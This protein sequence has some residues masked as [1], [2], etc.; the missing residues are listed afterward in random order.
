MNHHLLLL[1]SLFVFIPAS[2][3]LGSPQQPLR[4]KD[5]SMKE[6]QNHL[7]V[8]SWRSSLTTNLMNYCQQAYF[9]GQVIHIRNLLASHE[10]I[11]KARESKL[12]RDRALIAG[13]VHPDTGNNIPLFFSLP[14]MGPANL[15]IVAGMLTPNPSQVAVIFWQ[16]FNQFYNAG[17]NLANANKSAGELST[18]DV[19]T[20]MTTA[21]I[22]ACTLAV[23]MN[24]LARRYRKTHPR[25]GL[26]TAP[27]GVWG[28]NIISLF[29]MRHS[30]LKTGI[31]IKDEDGHNLGMSK[32]AAVQAIVRTIIS[33]NAIAG[34]LLFGP[35]LTTTAIFRRFPWLAVNPLRTK[36][37]EFLTIAIWL[38]TAIPMGVALYPQH[39]SM[40]TSQVEEPLRS[41]LRA[42]GHHTVHFNRGY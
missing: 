13:R 18:G 37:L 29:V 38:Y 39:D 16:F 20:S 28:G 2:L 12:L 3:V 26:L 19:A 14:A 31:V 42:Q 25:L 27:V 35:P 33:R 1:L 22:S 30:E 32:S 24:A 17:Q 34:A 40:R 4:K 9:I 8:P 15:L 5:N 21:S 36:S 7:T 23:G 6:Q 10:Q 41:Q 11:R